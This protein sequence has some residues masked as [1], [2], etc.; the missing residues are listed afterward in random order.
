MILKHSFF[1]RRRFL[2]GLLGGGFLALGGP[3]VYPLLRFTVPPRRPPDKVTLDLAEYGEM[4]PGTA[5]SFSW[6]PKP[7][8]LKKKDDGTFQA[9]IGV[10]THL[11]CNVEYRPGEDKFFCACHDGWYDGDGNNI[12][13]P[14]P[15]PLQKLDVN[16]EGENIIVKPES[17]A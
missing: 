7:A 9:F 10:C 15:R 14:P 16:I 1:D 8:I 2:N 11:D 17:T 3:V 13:G 5:R 4:K 12:A 6:G